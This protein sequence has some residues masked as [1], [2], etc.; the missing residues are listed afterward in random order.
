MQF[1]VIYADPPWFYNARTNPETRY[2]LG[3]HGHYS[4]EKIHLDGYVLEMRLMER[5]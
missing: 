4:L 2:S 1:D 5:R 3:V